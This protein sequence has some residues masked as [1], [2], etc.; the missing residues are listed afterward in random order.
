MFKNCFKIYSSMEKVLIDKMP[1]AEELANASIL[2]NEKFSFQ[3]AY[4]FVPDIQKRVYPVTF[5]IKSPLKDY[6]TAHYV[7]YV[8]GEMMLYPGFE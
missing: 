2:K 1:A 7:E 3:I 4:E 6:I 8:P 5:E